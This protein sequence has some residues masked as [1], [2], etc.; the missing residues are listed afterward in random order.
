MIKISAIA[1]ALLLGLILNASVGM[2]Q[3][4]QKPV[5]V[6]FDTDMGPD[7]DDVGAITLLHAFADKGEANILA[8][9]ASTKYEHVGP[10][11][12][13]LNTYFKRP[14]L[15][16]GVPR[17]DAS[18]LRDFQHWSDT[19][20]AR[21]PHAIKS[22]AET[23]DA[24]ELYRKV[25]AE[26]PDNSVTIITVGFLTNISNLLQSKAD[27]YSPLS[28]ADLINKKVDK[29]VSMAGKFPSGK[30]FNVEIDTKASVYVFKNFK[31]PIILSGFEIGA[32]IKTGLPLIHDDKIKNSPV[33]DVF[34]ISIPMDKE[35]KEGRMSW[36][37]TAVLVGV[38]GH[39]PY[40]KLSCGTMV[41][42]EDGSNAWSDK[43]KNHCHLVE[44]QPAS[45]VQKVINELMMHQP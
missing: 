8:T 12:N 28:G 24:V 19:L 5:S 4:N 33:K 40:Y 18:V 14:E 6:I 37:Q 44:K 45:V 36:D 42:N 30:E 2:A 11:L 10:V 23:L 7:Y 20:V 15:P 35:D 41:V 43:G 38:R 3:S 9:I 34:E 16:I 1:K 31:K 17:G 27:Q 22:N 26:Q 29:L 21:Y 25:L 39:E 13:V 32:K